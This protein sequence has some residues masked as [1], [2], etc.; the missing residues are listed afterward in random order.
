M[1]EL[2]LDEFEKSEWIDNWQLTREGYTLRKDIITLK[3][4][5]EEIKK[6]K[7]SLQKDYS[8]IRKERDK[9]YQDVR[10]LG[11]LRIHIGEYRRETANRNLYIRDLENDIRKLFNA[12]GKEITT[13]EILTR[14][15]K[16]KC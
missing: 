15:N 11:S 2:F 9:L 3:Y 10:E 12:I 6:E 5:L 4:D 16:P 8:D 7:A 1:Y 13:S 14:L